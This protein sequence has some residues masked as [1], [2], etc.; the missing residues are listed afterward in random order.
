MSNKNI[1]IAALSVITA[2]VVCSDIMMYRSYTKTE[3]CLEEY[4]QRLKA[5]QQYYGATEAL[6]DDID[7]DVSLEDTYLCGDVGSNYH[8]ALLKLD[9]ICS[10]K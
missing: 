9:S 10:L 6:L 1:A 2:V 7:K 5:Y 8:E 3:K 4:H